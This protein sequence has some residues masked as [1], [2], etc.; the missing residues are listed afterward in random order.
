MAEMPLESII[1]IIRIVITSLIRD[2]RI[3]TIKMTTPAPAH[4][5]AARIQLPSELTDCI[6]IPEANPR[7]TKATPRLAPELIPKT[8]GP[9]IGF[10]KTVCIWSP[11]T[12]SATPTVRAVIAFGTRNFIIIVSVVPEEP[13]KSAFI[14][15]EK[16]ILTEPKKIS[17]RNNSTSNNI[18]R[19]KIPETRL[20]YPLLFEFMPVSYATYQFIRNLFTT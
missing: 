12:A 9:A 4:A 10:L 11:L 7:I 1:P 5:A 16:R 14:T 13:E 18:N 2:E 6:E 8:Y 3:I 15:S 19:I 17:A 20:K